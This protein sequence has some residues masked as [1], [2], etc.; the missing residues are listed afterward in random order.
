MLLQF[1]QRLDII[2]DCFH[3]TAI[4]VA[5][6]LEEVFYTQFWLN[7]MSDLQSQPVVVYPICLELVTAQH[8]HRPPNHG[9]GGILIP[10]KKA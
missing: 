1:C 4:P 5:L 8:C 10:A 7:D 2:L 6:Y 9:I 3:Q